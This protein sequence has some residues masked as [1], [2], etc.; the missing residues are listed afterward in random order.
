MNGSYMSF[1]FEKLT[2]ASQMLCP[3]TTKKKAI[4]ESK[5]EDN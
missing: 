2:R 3:K 5:K 4:R 1:H